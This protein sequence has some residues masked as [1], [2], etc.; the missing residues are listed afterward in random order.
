MIFFN[1]PVV[2]FQN[3]YAAYIEYDPGIYVYHGISLW[4][5]MTKCS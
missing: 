3:E 5:G 2:N 1:W 4:R